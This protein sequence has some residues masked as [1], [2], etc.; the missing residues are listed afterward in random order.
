MEISQLL[1]LYGLPGL[2]IGGLAYAW[3]AE[4]Q[5]R[6]AAQQ[7]EKALIERVFVALDTVGQALKLVEDKK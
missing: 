4:R 7:S 5:E 6:M 2:I 3:R 1:E